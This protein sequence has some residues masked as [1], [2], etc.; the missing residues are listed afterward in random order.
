MNESP[1]A[2]VPPHKSSKT[3]LFLIVGLALVGAAIMLVLLGVGLFFVLKHEGHFASLQP[4]QPP[5]SLAEKRQA[6]AKAFGQGAETNEAHADEVKAFSVLLQLKGDDEA[7][8][9]ALDQP[10]ATL[11][12]S[13]EWTAFSMR[14]RALVRLKRFDEARTIVAGYERHTPAPYFRSMVEASAGNL[15]VATI[16]LD[17]LLRSYYGVQDLYQ[18]DLLGPALRS[19]GFADFR[20]RHPAWTIAATRLLER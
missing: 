20:E 10:S 14:V 11:T 16:A 6:S 2:D 15:P 4:R 1:W 13:A 5:E 12:K 9:R 3:G 19:D 17:E 18:D 7:L 8:L